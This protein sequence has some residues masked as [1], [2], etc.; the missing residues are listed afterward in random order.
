M[1]AVAY[2]TS[3]AIGLQVAPGVT[4]ILLPQLSLITGLETHVVKVV[5]VGLTVPL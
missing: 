2:P 4:T 5:C 3:P 1:E